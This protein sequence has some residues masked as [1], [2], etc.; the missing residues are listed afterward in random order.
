[1]IKLRKKGCSFLQIAF[2]CCIPS[3]SFFLFAS[4]FLF[5]SL[6]WVFVEQRDG[7][8]GAAFWKRK[9]CFRFWRRSLSRFFFLS[10]FILV[11]LFCLFVRCIKWLQDQHSGI[12]LEGRPPLPPRSSPTQVAAPA[13]A[14]INSINSNSQQ[15]AIPR[16]STRLFVNY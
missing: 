7:I 9:T 8:G 11:Y 15:A 4:L 3:A 12:S 1:M 14:I 10:F 13:A 16:V 2:F 5:N 6:K